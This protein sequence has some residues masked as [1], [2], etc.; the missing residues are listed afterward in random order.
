MTMTI[1]RP[2]FDPAMFRRA[3]GHV[4]TSVCVVTTADEQGIAGMTVGSFTSISLEPPLVGFFVDSG[5]STLTRLKNAGSFT[6]N[7][8]NDNQQDVCYAFA[9]PSE[10]RFD[11]I[12][13]RDGGHRHPRLVDA[14][15]WIEC[16]IDSTAVIGDHDAVIGRVVEL[17]VPA[18]PR[19]PLVFFRGKLCQLDARTIPHDGSW[20]RDHYAIDEW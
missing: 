10:D 3:L 1:E 15:G 7:L 13:L 6:V 16:E 20:R 9:R 19:S 14:V 5:S 2:T 11:G 4:P 8:L 17:D 18:L 12:G